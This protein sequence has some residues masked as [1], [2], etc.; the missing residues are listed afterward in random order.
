VGNGPCAKVNGL[1]IARLSDITAPDENA[2]TDHDYCKA[3]P[4][5]IEG[6]HV[7]IAGVDHVPYRIPLA[8]IPGTP[9]RIEVTMH[10]QTIP[11]YFLRDRFL[12][13]QEFAKRSKE[14][15]IAGLGSAAERLLY[16]SSRL[17]MTIANS[18]PQQS[19]LPP[20]ASSNWTM[21]IGNAY[22]DL[23]PASTACQNCE[24]NQQQ[25]ALNAA[26]LNAKENP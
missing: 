5:T 2:F 3:N 20:L 24:Q 6:Q 9:A 4:L 19:N 21:H 26:S 15:G 25:A 18:I 8:D 14:G 17:N 13:G 11:P 16:I 1:S 10:Y 12:D 22:I 23:Q 7:G